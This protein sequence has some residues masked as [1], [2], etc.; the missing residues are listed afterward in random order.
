M[1][2]SVM[3]ETMG[4]TQA[5]SCMGNTIGKSSSHRFGALNRRAHKLPAPPEA[6]VTSGLEKSVHLVLN[7]L[8]VRVV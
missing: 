4:E 8:L 1:N 5:S 6:G 7:I 3:E 2:I